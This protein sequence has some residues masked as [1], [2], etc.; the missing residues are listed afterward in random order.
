MTTQPEHDKPSSW[1]EPRGGTPGAPEGPGVVR[2]T[3][4]TAKRILL[5][6]IGA[7]V[8]LFAVFNSQNVEVKWFFGDPIQTPLI[9]ALAITF[10]AGLAIGWLGAK[11]GKRGS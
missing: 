11:L 10:V 7:L 3:T 6:V 1:E 2:R 5:V 4:N 8:A 9:L